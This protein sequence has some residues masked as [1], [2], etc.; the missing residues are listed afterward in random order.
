MRRRWQW[1]VPTR[2]TSLVICS[3]A[4]AVCG[5]GEQESNQ[6]PSSADSQ[7]EDA[8]INYPLAYFAERIGGEHVLVALAPP[9]EVDPAYWQPTPDAIAGIQA[10]DLI[11]LNGAD[12]AK[13][14]VTAT[15]PA[16]RVVVTADSAWH[17]FIIVDETVTHTHG[18]EGDHSHGETAF[19][20]WLDP[21]IAIIQAQAIANAFRNARPEQAAAFD[22][23]L[24]ALVQDLEALDASFRDALGAIPDGRVVASHPVYQYLAARYD[25]DVISVDLEPGDMPSERQWLELQ[26]VHAGHPATVM[27]W[28]GEPPPE[29]RERLASMGLRVAVVDPVANLPDG[30]NYLSVMNSNVA[31][32]RQAVAS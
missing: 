23:N 30:G 19:T 8:A 29:T 14:V 2:R 28:E 6:A 25:L 1:W 16:S 20:T 12:Y 31:N 32:I 15:L 27:L 11:L 21:T 26:R 17:R 22:A 18:P 13:W 9:A 10:A 24:R 3:V 7:L 5:G 4:A